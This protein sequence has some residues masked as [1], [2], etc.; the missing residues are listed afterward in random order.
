VTALAQG[1]AGMALVIC[2]ALLRTRQVG[3]ALTLLAVQSVGVALAAL[4]QHQPLIAVATVAIGVF[5][6]SWLL[7]PQAWIVKQPVVTAP[8]G[9]AK[10]GIIVGAGLAV[11]CQS[12]GALGLPLAVTL[13]SI[14]L[15]ATRDHPVMRFIALVSLQ[16][17]VALAACLVAAAPL[18]ALA[19]FVLPVALT[20]A[21]TLSEARW[22]ELS[23]KVRVLGSSSPLRNRYASVAAW[24]QR[25]FGW[26]HLAL[27]IG[28]FSMSLTMPIDSLGSIFAPLIGAEGIAQAW[29]AR[30][31]PARTLV[32]R[33]AALV[34][35][36][37]LLLAVGTSGPVFA[38]FAI[39]AAMT[40]AIL[41]ALPR[42]WNSALLAL[43][44]AGLAL[45]GL[46]TITAALPAV[47]YTSLFVGYAAMAAVVPELGIVILVVFLRLTLT[48]PL[49]PVASTAAICIAVAALFYCMIFLWNG[50]ARHRLTLLLLAQIS[51]GGLTIGLGLPDARFAATI[52]LVLLILNRAA[53]RLADGPAAAAAMAGLGGIP[54]FGVFPGLVLVL[55][56]VAGHAP[57]LL[58]PVGMALVIMVTASMPMKH[59][60]S[61]MRTS[62]LS[63]GWVP[64]ALCFLFGFFAPPDLVQWLRALTG[65]VS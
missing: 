17:G 6:A 64:L 20:I 10:L 55:L 34:K 52:L 61:S 5:G 42:R 38:W 32:Q 60:S 37:M 47:S 7:R 59:A 27:S 63:V 50:N 46:L 49:P 22:G 25:Q 45:F 31:R 13:L 11:L 56:V 36:A 30:Y 54:P 29:A 28:L 4:V 48:T 23:L 26:I 3:A 62:F 12:C 39:V 43:S 19:C 35:L 8:V 15:A 24:L 58:L 16:N 41:P 18:P 44:A 65:G 21:T 40:A 51:I 1:M 57:W 9:G 53:I 2:F 33:S 14:L